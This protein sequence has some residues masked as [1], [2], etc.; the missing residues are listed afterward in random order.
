M[1]APALAAQAWSSTGEPRRQQS[2]DGDPTKAGAL[3]VT[4]Q[5]QNLDV[6]SFTSSF[7]LR[8]QTVGPTFGS[9]DLNGDGVV[10]ALLDSV[11]V[12]AEPR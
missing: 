6:G 10:S 11:E 7:E 2:A 3:R 4:R 12:E 1:S 9:G 5:N 8:F